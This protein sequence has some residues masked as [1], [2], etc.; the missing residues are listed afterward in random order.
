[1]DIM[2]IIEARSKEVIEMVFFLWGN[3]LL[4]LMDSHEREGINF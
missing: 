4:L 2:D 3:K 1:M